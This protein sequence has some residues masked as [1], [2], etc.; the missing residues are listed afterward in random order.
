MIILMMHKNY[1]M[2]NFIMVF[3]FYNFYSPQHLES[4]SVL[5]LS[6][7]WL[8]MVWSPISAVFPV[9]CI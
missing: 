5:T 6:S 9:L 2:P 4:P 1:T 3:R 8:E 7:K